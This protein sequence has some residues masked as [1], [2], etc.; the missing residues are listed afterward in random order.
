MATGVAGVRRARHLEA[1]YA[2]RLPSREPPDMHVANNQS[3][4][5]SCQRPAIKASTLATSLGIISNPPQQSRRNASG[6][7]GERPVMPLPTPNQGAADG[8]VEQSEAE[9]GQQAEPHEPLILGPPAEL[10]HV[11]RAN[12]LGPEHGHEGAAE[13]AGVRVGRDGEVDGAHHGLGEQDVAQAK[14]GWEAGYAEHGVGVVGMRH[15]G[16]GKTMLVMLKAKETRRLGAMSVVL[17][18]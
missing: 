12:V 3:I 15:G 8:P 10:K 13:G 4:Q 11:R 17:P 5:R 1:R 7:R 16:S 9:G 14:G 18:Y 2:T 6:N